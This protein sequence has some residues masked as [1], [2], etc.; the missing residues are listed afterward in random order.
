MK[1]VA[2]LGSGFVI[3]PAVDYFLDKCEY[4][5]IL[6]SVKKEEAEKIINNRPGGTAVCWTIDNLDLLDKIVSEVDIVM[7]MIPPFMHIPV[8]K[9]CLKHKTNMVTTS[10]ISEEMADL[11]AEAQKQNILILNE[12]GEDPGLDNMGAKQLI[13][14]VKA[15]NGKV[16]GLKSYGAGLPSFDHNNNPW[17]YKFS[18]SPMGVILA[19]KTPAA[20]LKDGK[21]IDVPAEKLFHHCSPVEFDEVGSFE[22]YP[23]RD[24]LEYVSHLGLD[25]DVSICRGVLRFPGW[26]ETMKALISLNLLDNSDQKIFEGLTYAKFTAS[27]IGK[28]SEEGL[29]AN[30]AKFLGLEENSSIMEKLNWLGLF[31]TDKICIPGG[32]NAELLVNLMLQKMSY[33]AGEKDMVI[34]ANEVIA[35]F[36]DRREMWSG[37]MCIEGIPNGDSAMSRAVSL[38]AAISTKLILEGK[39][40]V[41]GVQ[42][43][44]SA[45]IYTPVLNEVANLGLSFNHKITQI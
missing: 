7:S 43:P 17:G 3:K 39:I 11:Q 20:Y 31:A 30:S 13:D 38:P 6:T 15:Q 14:Q 9:A 19:A 32:T 41:K 18:W 44:L 5:V 36:P 45:E 42:R 24:S 1:K 12:V 29:F 37:V 2:V 8:A 4:E 28:D 35:E 34:V 33:E 21:K 25:E 10:Y 22:T 26:C 27:L 23:N 40:T 16:T